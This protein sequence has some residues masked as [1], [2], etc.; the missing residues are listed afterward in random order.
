[1]TK[2]ITRRRLK[3]LLA[4]AT[5]QDFAQVM[6]ECVSWDRLMLAFSNI[7][8][9]KAQQFKKK[10]QKRHW[11]GKGRVFHRAMDEHILSKV[12]GNI[13]KISRRDVYECKCKKRF[14]VDAALNKNIQ[15]DLS[16]CEFVVTCPHCG[17][18]EDVQKAHAVFKKLESEPKE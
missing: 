11:L 8:W 1:M 4:Q 2:P 15:W 10:A 5:P 7:A 18:Q 3:K 9:G 13:F 12:K 16:Q 6:L 14:T 17:K